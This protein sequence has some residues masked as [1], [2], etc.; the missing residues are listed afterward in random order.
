[1]LTDDYRVKLEAFEGPLDLLLFLIRKSEV[2]VTDIPVSVIADQYM[3]FLRHIDRIDIDAAGEFLVMAAT[4]MEIKSRMLAAR[5][6]AEGAQDGPAPEAEEDPRAE[7]VRQLLA[8]KQFRDAA[9]ALDRRRDEW[10]RRFPTGAAA[11]DRESLQ[12]AIEQQLEG[13]ELEDVGVFDLAEA[14]RRICESVNFDRLGEHQVTYDDTP[15]ELH[16]QD[17]LDRLKRDAGAGGGALAFTA[18][19]TG[20]SRSEMIGLFLAVLDLVRRRALLVEQEA[21]TGDIMLRARPEADDELPEVS[22]AGGVG[23]S[24]EPGTG[25]EGEAREAERG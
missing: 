1:M 14:F 5:P 12:Q 7:L 19:F 16:A 10:E 23:A 21:I 6:A 18:V 15:I 8:Y 25:E 9:D 20:R 17:I 3:D 13:V 24:E 22:A 11:I 2:E 4:L